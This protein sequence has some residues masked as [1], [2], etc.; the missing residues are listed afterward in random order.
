MTISSVKLSSINFKKHFDLNYMTLADLN[1]RATYDSSSHSIVKNFII[2]A[3]KNSVFYDRGVGFFTAGWLKEAS[4]GMATF[5]SNGGKARWITSP[6]LYESDLKA[7]LNGEE[8]KLDQVLKQKLLLQVDDV[9]QTLDQDTLTAI[10][11]MVADEIIEFKIALP[12][13]R[14]NGGDF[15]DKFGIFQDRSGLR[16]SFSGSYNDSIKGSFNYESIKVFH[17][18][19]FS[20]RNFVEYDYLRFERLWRNKDPNVQVFQVPEAVKAKIIRLRKENSRPYVLPTNEHQSA[21]FTVPREVFPRTYQCEA[22]NAWIDNEFMGILEMATGTGKTIT[23]ILCINELLK[24]TPNLF[25]IIVSPFLHLVDQWVTECGRFNLTCVPCYE[26]LDKWHKTLTSKLQR[27]SIQASL[28]SG[29]A[30]PIVAATTFPTFT[31]TAFQSLVRSLDLPV[32]VIADEVHHMGS[33]KHLKTLSEKLT[34][35]LGLSATPERWFDESGTEKLKEFFHGIV[36]SLGLKEAIYEYDVLSRYNYHI[37]TVRLEKEEFEEYKIL[38]LQIAQRLQK[39]KVAFDDYED[40]ILSHLL[41]ERARVLNNASGKLP[42]LRNLLG[43]QQSISYTLIY[44]SPEH[45]DAINRM[46]VDMRILSH[47]ITYRESGKDRLAILEAFE[48]G[49]YKAL[50]AIK[51][52]DEGVDIPGIR[53]AYLLASTGNPR[54]FT[55]RRGRI[56]RKAEG[57]QIAII[58][59]FVTLPTEQPHSLDEKLFWV[60][61]AIVKHEI[62]RLHHF[63]DC[64]ENKH[65]ALLK[66]YDLASHYGLQDILVG[67]YDEH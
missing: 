27:L 21:E 42:L 32:F 55:Q 38:S 7:I 29:P 33:P 17:S 19:D 4:T 15:H 52:L 41:R 49:T 66:L 60:E 8:A 3:L 62:L 6:I 2:P 20:L 51:C 45:I 28:N 39:M 1:L 50:T 58:N 10:S 57:K 46:L 61:K 56:L 44:T 47:Q 53:T 40:E 26:S 35:R 54:E 36:F 11:W 48:Q 65:E 67:G 63:A 12:T 24:T 16:V 23:A 43:S 13:N 18:W 22:I 64:A 59:D 9:A 5:A 37:H 34:F 30:A 31:S 14:L 25:V